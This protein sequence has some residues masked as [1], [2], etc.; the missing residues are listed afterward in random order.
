MNKR[1]I[2]ALLLLS[3]GVAVL[4]GVKWLQPRLQERKLRGTSDASATLGTI[5][6]ARDSWIGY[7]PL[8][9]GRTRTLARQ[10]GWNLVCEDD[11][12]DLGVRMA[13][14][15]SG[16]I[17]MAVA[18]VDSYLLNGA[19]VDYPGAIVMVIDESLGG[20]A[21]VAREQAAKNLDA[22]RGRDDLRVAYTPQSPSHHLLKATA[23]HFNL[24]ELLPP[25]GPRRIETQ[26]SAEALKKLLSGTTD[27]A[28]LW[29]P[30]VSR[31]LR[32]EGTVKLLGTEDTRRLIVDVLVAGRDFLQKRPEAVE[33]LLSS[34]FKTLKQYRDQPELL[35]ADVM[36]ETGLDQETAKAMLAGVAWV[37]L[38]ENC[39]DWFGIAG[40][41][42]QGSEGISLT[43]ESTAA[44]LVGARD[45]PASP[46]P[47]QNPYRLLKRSFLEDLYL[48]GVSGF[49]T[50][51]Q[52]LGGK[53]GDPLTAP[54]TAMD[55]AQWDRLSEVGTLKINPIIFMHGSTELD[56]LAQAEID[57]AVER[58]RH[59][60]RFRVIVKGHTGTRGDSAE[61]KLLSQQRAEV[62]AAYLRSRHHV[63]GNRIRALGF[64]DE[65][66]LKQLEGESYRAYQQRLLRVE[67]VLVREDF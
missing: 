32:A 15:A 14:L 23:T 29:E 13:R 64:G 19:A 50:S 63:D 55:P 58:L 41:S 65:R 11:Q 22:V 20:D 26:G 18:T 8:C 38:N 47:D 33:A 7:F 35:L 48:K 62:V 10:S 21:I 9:S 44:I 37:N 36:A 49:Q 2:G 30:D 59:Y 52:A 66:P 57:Q 61:N 27:V 6:L 51:G 60:P 67:V 12:A 34:Y 31:A 4:F 56:L 46:V 54:F 3:L 17:E 40:P 25:A 43:I 53:N 39:E 24:N 5:R 45:F 1:I 42:G 28:V 16:E